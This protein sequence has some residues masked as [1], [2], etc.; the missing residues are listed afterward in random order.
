MSRRRFPQKLE[1][2][3][4]SVELALIIPVLLLLL[5][6]TF[7]LSWMVFLSNMTSQAAR[8]GAR[9]AIVRQSTNADGSCQTSVPSAVA[10]PVAAAARGQVAA[11][12]S[13]AY[14]VSATSG[15]TPA[16]GCYVQVAVST[17]YQ[18]VASTFLP[19]GATQVGA[20]SRLA[21]P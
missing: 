18:P 16:D 15:G 19:V 17:T 14:A 3:T 4:S 7:D 5:I 21:L 13:S 8:E 6:G 1:R 2:A 20:T 10:T 9:A 11:F 12:G